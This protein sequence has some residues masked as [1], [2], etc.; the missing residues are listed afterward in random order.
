[1]RLVRLEIQDFGVFKGRNRF[2]LTPS[3]GPI[4]LFGGKNGSGKT[5]IFEAI[6]LCLY[7][8]RALGDRVTNNEYSNHMIDLI[9]KDKNISQPIKSAKVSIDFEYASIGEIENYHI[10]RT[11]ENKNGSIGETLLIQ[12]NGSV[13]SEAAQERWQDFIEDIIPLG[14]SRLFF[15]DGEKVQ[16]LISDNFSEQTLGE[17]IKR[18]LSLHLIE[19]LQAD[20]DVYQYRQR[21][22]NALP[23]LSKALLDIEDTLKEFEED[24]NKTL[25]DRGST[26]NKINHVKG[27]I[28]NTERK[29]SLESSGFAF[30]RENLKIEKTKIETEIAE[31]E[32]NLRELASELLPFTLV[33]ELSINIRKQLLAEAKKQEWRAYKNLLSDKLIAFRKKLKGAIFW[34]TNKIIL[35]KRDMNSIISLIDT[36]LENLLIEPEEIELIRNI[37]KV[38]ESERVELLSWID[39]SLS[40]IPLRIKLSGE[41]LEKLYLLQQETSMRL[42]KIPKDDVINPLMQNLSTLNK[43]LGKLNELA[44]N[45]DNKLAAVEH[46]RSEAERNLRITYDKLISVEKKDNKLLLSEKVVKVVKNFSKELKQQKIKEL[47]SMVVARFNELSRKDD[48]ISEITIDPES[49]QIH[50]ARKNGS[51]G[52]NRLSAGEKQIFAIA[53]LWALRQISNKPFPVVIDTPLGRL[54]SDHRDN[55]INNYFPHVSHQVIL[56]STDTEVDKQYFLE[57]NSNISHAYH[58]IFNQSSGQTE[59]EQGY[60]W[61]NS[62]KNQA[63]V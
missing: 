26:Q 46:K 55:L 40:D 58:L 57:L 37:H 61:R 42:W 5:T 53:L 45:L 47:E 15:F 14:I 44:K 30:D 62:T 19:R 33:P 18:L 25:H 20:L 34:K 36:E 35:K 31:V 22:E 27:Q 13:L 38:S 52:K 21:K 51:L 3:E 12:K 11:W 6:R 9:H 59:V 8:K 10:M 23:V 29:L 2:N 7:G 63:K 60:F 4:I 17:E 16:S 24:F 41:R 54:D 43:E 32:N 48:L 1:M 56:F 39:Q 50:L 28:E 49:F